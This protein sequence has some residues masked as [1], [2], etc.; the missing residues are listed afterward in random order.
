MGIVDQIH[1]YHR[2][3]YLRS[4]KVVSLNSRTPIAERIC[5][6]L[7]LKCDRKSFPLSTV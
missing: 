2:F 7:S 4:I 1:S 5:E 3:G 6:V